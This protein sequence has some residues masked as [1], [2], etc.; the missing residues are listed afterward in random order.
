MSR[1]TVFEYMPGRRTDMIEHSDGRT[2]FNTYQDVEP[3]I[4]H[5]KMMMNEYGDKLTPGKRG[6]WHRVASIP[7]NVWEQWLSATD[8]AIEKDK[9]LLN[10]Y[11]NDPDNKF[12][13]TSP[14]N[15]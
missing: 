13:R 5:N 7:V 15:L 10:K 9:K 4:E 12:F 1:R 6:T 11:L 8:Q 3:I 14:T 2:T